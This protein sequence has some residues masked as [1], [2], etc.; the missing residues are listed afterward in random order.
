MQ[1]MTQPNNNHS[2]NSQ[3]QSIM[4]T[5]ITLFALA[6][7]ILGFSVGALTHHS[8]PTSLASNNAKT[9]SS[10]DKNA[11]HTNVATSPTAIPSPTATA[12]KLGGPSMAISTP[13]SSTYTYKI[14]VQATYAGTLANVTTNGITCRLWITKSDPSKL[15]SNSFKVISNLQQTV[16]DEIA[17]GLQF[18]SGTPQTQPCTNGMGTWNANPSTSLSKGSYYIVGLTDWNGTFYNWSWRQLQLG[19]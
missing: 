16:P 13:L 1:H 4:I 12:Q 5:A 11:T 9:N 7:A 19:Q 8:T 2:G 14:T 10:T 17:G 15:D 6:G 18:D 3:V